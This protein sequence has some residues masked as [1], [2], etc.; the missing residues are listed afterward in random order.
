MDIS[1]SIMEIQELG[2]TVIEDFMT[3]DQVET[4]RLA[5]EKIEEKSGFGSGDFGGHRTVRSSNLVAKTRAFDDLITDSRMMSLVSGVIG[6]DFQLSIAT[7]IK[8]YPGE[9]PQPLHQDDGLWPA[10]RPHPPFVL[11]TLYAIDPFTC[12]NGGTQLVA[13][14]H[15]STGPVDQQ[16]KKVSVEMP[17]GSV[18]AWD[19]ATWHGGG[20]N[21]TKTET[22]CGLNIN[23][24]VAWLKQ[25]ENQFVGVHPDVAATLPQ[26]LQELLGY[27]VVHQILGGVAGQDPRE[28]LLERAGH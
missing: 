8:I 21:N 20:A 27:K 14:T 7:I 2:Y 9:T 16:A 3:E 13:G 25:Q 15:K 22:R 24:N 17:V 28:I 5:I 18:L 10:P 23:Y 11:N 19:G 6:A 26:K 1:E 4:A 12:E